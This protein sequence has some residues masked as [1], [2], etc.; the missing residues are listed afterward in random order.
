MVG[1]LEE[2]GLLAREQAARVRRFGAMFE[3]VRLEAV[4]LRTVESRRPELDS[5]AISEL[6]AKLELSRYRRRLGQVL[7]EA[8]ALASEEALEIERLSRNKLQREDLRVLERY[9]GEDFAGVARPLLP[10]PRVHTG[11][12][13]VTTLFRSKDTLRRVKKA[14]VRLE[15]E[16]HSLESHEPGLASYTGAEA[17]EPEL[18]PEELANHRAATTS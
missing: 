9:Q 1:Q 16:R 18:E 7:I 8:R 17:E 15:E 11:V 10:V 14:L 3:H 6:L 2:E 12:F 4:Y 13:R 5:G